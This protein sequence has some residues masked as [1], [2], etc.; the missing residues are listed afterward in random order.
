MA[1]IPKVSALACTQ[2][3]QRDGDLTALGMNLTRL[4]VPAQAGTQTTPQRTPWA[5]GGRERTPRCTLWMLLDSR[6]RG[7]DGIGAEDSSLWQSKVLF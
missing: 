6:L 4:V 2:V 7:N 1:Q 5:C 3:F